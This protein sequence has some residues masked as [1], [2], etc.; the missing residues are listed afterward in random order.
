MNVAVMYSGGKDSNYA[1]QHAIEK[2]WS[3]KYLL[4]VK[5]TRTDCYL[6]HF[7]TVEHTPVQAEALGLKHYLLGCSVADPKAEAA[8]VEKFVAGKQKSKSEKVDAVILGGTGLQAT[9]IRSLQDA[10]R[11]YGIEVFAAHSGLDHF[12]VLKQMIEKGYEIII[13]QVASEGLPDWLGKRIT[14]ENIA[15]LDADSI[16]FGFHVG[17]EGGYYDSFVADAPMFGKS[18]VIKETEKVMEDAYSG[19]VIIKQLKLADKRILEACH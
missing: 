3:I 8:I 16:K 9:Q 17:G 18:I 19:H 14:K 13:T 7:A 6:F 5:P 10:L 15:R 4:S 12:D 2:G 11:P 1:V